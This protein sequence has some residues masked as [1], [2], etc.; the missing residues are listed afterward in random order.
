VVLHEALEVEVSELV[1]LA[2]L[3]KLGELGIGVDLA[4]ICLVLKTMGLD[5]GI[6][7]LAH[8]S[9][10]H[11]SANCLSKETSKL[12]GDAGGLNETRGLAVA[13]IAA[14]LR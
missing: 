10:S 1:L 3:E 2:K 5:V 7:L 6:E 14:L 9:A 4:T 11:L 13:V 12:V 8:V